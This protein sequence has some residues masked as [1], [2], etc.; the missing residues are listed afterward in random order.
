MTGEGN[1]L[2][3]VDAEEVSRDDYHLQEQVGFILRKAHQRHV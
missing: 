3:I 2:K 1:L